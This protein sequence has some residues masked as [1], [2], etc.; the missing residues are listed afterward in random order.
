MTPLVAVLCAVGMVVVVPL[1]LR[2]LDPPPQARW[3]R[4]WPVLGLV[5][6]ASTLLPRGDAAALLAGAYL[7][8][9][10]RLALVAAARLLRTRSLAPVEVAALTALVTPS[11]AGLSLVAERGGWDLLGFNGTEHALTVAHFHFAGF[12]AALV[13]GLVARSTTSPLGPVGALAVPV[14]TFVVLVGYFIGEP[15]ELAGTV[16]L[17]AGMWVVGL[18]VWR[19][20][21]PEARDGVTRV[22]LGTGAVT[23]AAT[24]V[25]ALS[26]AAGHVW[27]AVPHLSLTWMAATH[28]VAN[29]LGFAVCTLLGWR[30]LVAGREPV[31]AG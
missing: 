25:L 24:M 29:A 2:L 28:G 26:W 22:L 4:A 11:I 16:V 31:P 9:T 19:D 21:R 3:L 30:R 18:L 7:T 15:V 5:G 17:T 23:L 27:D 14:G 6:A 12:A 20:V 1:G 8:A 10:V 13:S